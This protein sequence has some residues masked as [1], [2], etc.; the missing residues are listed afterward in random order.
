MIFLYILIGIIIGGVGLYLLLKNKI[1]ITQEINQERQEINQQINQE[2][3]KLLEEKANIQ[4]E[5]VEINS[6]YKTLVAQRAEIK[7]DYK[8]LIAQ[9][10][11]LKNNLQD[12]QDT[13]TKAAETIY[14]QAL[15]V[16]QNNFDKEIEKISEEL[17]QNRQ[18]AQD[19]YLK[20]LKES[21]EE[22]QKQI[23]DKQ[24]QLIKLKEQIQKEAQ[25]VACAVEAAQRQLEMETKQD[26]YRLNLSNEDIMEINKLREVLPYLRD[27]E[28]LNKVIYKSYYEKPYTD[29]VGRVIGPGIHTGIYKITN[30]QNGMCYVGQA[31]NIAERW[32]QHIKRG[33]GA[34]APTRNKLYPAMLT[35]GVENFTFEVIEEC[36]R[37]KLDER[38]DYWQDY[39]HAKDFGY[40]IK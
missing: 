36:D 15:Q 4:S 30:I 16:S 37:S 23:N 20:T 7:A 38:E 12:L 31:A 32:R 35:F 25:N 18:D 9:R 13:Q 8:T 11:E 40:S 10:V 34:E 5:I 22:F 29:L 26:Y 3:K 6:D 21:V 28:P 19:E 17:E 27:K 39:F 14:Q 1:K 33:V 2:N 24:Q